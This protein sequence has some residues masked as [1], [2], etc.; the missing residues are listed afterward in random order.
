M[1]NQKENECSTVTVAKKA[2]TVTVKQKKGRGSGAWSTRQEQE[3][4]QLFREGASVEALAQK[5]KRTPRTV[6]MKLGRLGLDV[7]AAKIDVSGQLDIPEEPPSLED[8]LK[9]VAAAIFKASQLGLGKTEL[10]RLDT[11]ATLYKAYAAGLGN[12]IGY[13]KIGAFKKYHGPYPFS[14][15]LG[16]D[17]PL[18]Q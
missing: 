16:G 11:I 2:S 17:F 9:I 5:F 14:I 10:Q 18:N 13:R 6:A 15:P 8:V 1:S 7:A 12:Y 3:L 4:I